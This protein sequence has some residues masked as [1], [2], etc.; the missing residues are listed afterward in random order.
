MVWQ[1]NI[2]LNI[3]IIFI[4]ISLGTSLYIFRYRRKTYNSFGLLF[5]FFLIE[6][7]FAEYFEYSFTPIFLKTIFDKIAY[8]GITSIPV[9]WFLFTLQF[10]NRSKHINFKTI[11]LLSI[12]PAITLIL[13]FTNEFHR[14][15]W[16]RVYINETVS[17]EL[18]K[19]YNIFFWIF[20]L[21]LFFFSV[22]GLVLISRFF[23]KG[24][25]YYQ[26]QGVLLIFV[27]TVPLLL[28]IFGIF[29]IK[30]FSYIIVT[31]ISITL[32]IIFSIFALDRIRK[33]IIL[34]I[35]IDNIIE[36]IEDGVLILSPE[37]RIVDLNPA[38]EKMFNT[39]VKDITGKNASELLP[40]A[41]IDEI[42][43]KIHLISR[44]EIQIKRKRTTYYYDLSISDI[45]DIN[46]SL[47][48]KVIVARNITDRVRSEEEIKY[49]GFHDNL[50][51]LYNR[52]YFEEEI[53]RLD[54]PN[55]LPISIVIGDV[56][57]IKMIND[58]FGHKVGDSL[59]CTFAKIFKDYLGKENIITRWGG[60]EFAII[61]PGTSKK[62]AEVIIDRIRKAI[63]NYP[64]KKV[65]LSMA[66]GSA[67]KGNLNVNV[68]GVIIEAEDNMYR[69]KLLE[70]RS[71][72]SSI[73]SSLE[74]TI[75][76]KSHETEE[77]AERLNK[78]AQKLGK[79]FGLP[80][81]MLND[82]ALLSSLHDI[83]KI[84]IPEEILLKES[85]LT[86]N[87]WAIIKRHSAIGYNIAKSSTQIAHLADVILHHHEWWDG[88]GYP[89]GLKGEQ[90]PIISRI[91]SIVDAYDVMR[92]GRPYKRKMSKDKAIA[93]LRRF[94]GQQFDPELVEIFIN[95][96][97]I[98]EKVAV[99]L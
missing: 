58:V 29:K 35:A 80:E 17:Y 32:G 18:I 89:Q 36:S 71:V 16:K 91:I 66:L 88:T 15:I 7:M 93:E 48:G 73:I 75:F 53:K 44:K 68:Q 62:D 46:N 24:K 6:W 60:D 4:L 84:A 51:G 96:V 74:R 25:Y 94:S 14:L 98:D 10:T 27:F 34:P 19:D 87:E 95:K 63:K 76:E 50:T 54:T 22:F 41:N 55:Q 79:T 72:S 78:F 33:N 59:L 21:Y 20:M 52:A 3:F 86:D 23:L 97:L 8:I 13:A 49:L 45:I 85:K 28:S 47:I 30:P 5:L 99:R 31:P 37:N 26:W 38:A 40:N 83:G 2:Y 1:S 57:G 42:L 39:T 43:N 92:N 12:L 77:H 81:N 56:N 9:L 70:K 64:N 11:S 82:L 69:R 67:T 90:I 65:P 61:L